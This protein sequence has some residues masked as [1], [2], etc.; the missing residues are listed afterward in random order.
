[1]RDGQLCLVSDRHVHYA[2]A[3]ASVCACVY[4]DGPD[5]S[6]TA[7]HQTTRRMPAGLHERD[8]TA[9]RII[10]HH[11]LP[12]THNPS[13]RE[14]EP[15]PTHQS[16]SDDAESARSRPGPGP[17]SPV[18]SASATSLGADVTVRVRAG[19]RS[20]VVSVLNA[21]LVLLGHV[22]MRPAWRA[23][24]CCAHTSTRTVITL[25]SDLSVTV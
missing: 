3:T 15:H 14:F 11:R 24:S 16:T 2:F 1:M 22:L 18:A 10:R 19:L 21:L 8:T 9:R 12:A 20:F 23:S 4:A 25:L 5:L 13:G 17:N 7:H 6:D